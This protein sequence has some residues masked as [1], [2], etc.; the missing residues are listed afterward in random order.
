MLL[1]TKIAAIFLG[2]GCWVEVNRPVTFLWS[3]SRPVPEEGLVW[4]WGAPTEVRLLSG[5]GHC[6]SLAIKEAPSLS[7]R[8]FFLGGPRE[9]QTPNCVSLSLPPVPGSWW[10]LWGKGWGKGGSS[11]VT[12][13]SLL[14]LTPRTV[15]S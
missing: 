12:F 4:V 15:C 9:A 3:P 7:L 13:G 1:G 5:L 11:S 14:S 8:V 6:L 10:P 2:V